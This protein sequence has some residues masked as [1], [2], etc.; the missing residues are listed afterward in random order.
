MIATSSMA[1]NFFQTY[2]SGHAIRR[3]QEQVCLTASI[4]RDDD[5][6]DIGRESKRASA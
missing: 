4:L 3:L 2:R 6:Q 1:I 5:W